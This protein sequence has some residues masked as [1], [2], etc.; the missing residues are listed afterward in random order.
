[1]TITAQ[2]TAAPTTPENPQ[3][4]PL[5]RIVEREGWIGAYRAGTGA[6][7]ATAERSKG[8]EDDEWIGWAVQAHCRKPQVVITRHLARIVLIE[9]A[10]DAVGGVR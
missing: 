3:V 6:L 4:S 8:R 1:M 5:V 7:L 10:N 9:Y 2:P